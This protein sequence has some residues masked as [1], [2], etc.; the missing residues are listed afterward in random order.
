V[1]ALS[2]D[3]PVTKQA[4]KDQIRSAGKKIDNTRCVKVIDQLA[5]DGKL[6]RVGPKYGLP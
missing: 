6:A 2:D 4:I 1:Y 3:L 5:D